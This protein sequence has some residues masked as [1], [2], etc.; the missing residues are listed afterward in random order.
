MFLDI[1]VVMVFVLLLII[2]IGFAIF[3]LIAG[4]IH[5]IKYIKKLV[6]EWSDD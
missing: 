2:M 5:A 4:T 1:L 3:F 6:N